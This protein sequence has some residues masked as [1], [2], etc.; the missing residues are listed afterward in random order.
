MCLLLGAGSEAGL[1]TASVL[2][3]VLAVVE[4]AEVRTAALIVVEEF[5]TGLLAR[6]NETEEMGGLQHRIPPAGI[7]PGTNPSSER[8]FG[9]NSRRNRRKRSRQAHL[10]RVLVGTQGLSTIGSS[11]VRS[12]G[13]EKRSDSSIHCEN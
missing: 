1:D 13:S 3:M 9:R 10:V 8:K 12:L 7:P 2:I 11:T 6:T 4:R 5:G